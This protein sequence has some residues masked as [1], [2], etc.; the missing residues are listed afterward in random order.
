MQKNESAMDGTG[1]N[2]GR[3]NDFF[4]LHCANVLGKSNMVSNSENILSDDVFHSAVY[5]LSLL[6]VSGQRVKD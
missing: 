2:L 6:Y 1:N 3:E 5:A 4:R